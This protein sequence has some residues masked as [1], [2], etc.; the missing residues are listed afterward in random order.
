MWA[1]FICIERTRMRP[2][3]LAALLVAV[4]GAVFRESQWQVAITARHRSEELVVVRAV[5]GFEVVAVTLI[6]FINDTHMLLRKADQC[7]RSF[8]HFRIDIRLG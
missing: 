6:E 8:P 5:H 2:K 7:G 1:S 4:A 3:K